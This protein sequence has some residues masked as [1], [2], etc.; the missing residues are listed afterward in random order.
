[1]TRWVAYRTLPG[2]EPPE[3]KYAQGNGGLIA[4]QVTGD[5]PADLV[6]MTGL[7]S[8]VD[9]RWDVPP[10]ARFLE[11]LSS[12]SRVISFDR[13]G[14]GAS[15][16]IPSGVLTWE[17]CADDLKVVLD[18]IACERAAIFAEVD[19]GPT[20]LLFAAMFPD[21]VSALVLA[22]GAARLVADDGYPGVPLEAASALVNMTQQGW[23]TE[24]WAE[25]V[26]ASVAQDRRTIRSLA[27]LQRAS[28][29]PTVAARRFR[30]ALGLDIRGVLSSIHVPTLIIQREQ[31][32]FVPTSIGRHLAENIPGA[33]YFE[34][35]G[36]DILCCTQGDREILER[37]QKF[38]TGTSEAQDTDRVL[39]TVLF[40]DI[41]D[42]TRRAAEAGDR[43]WKQLLDAHDDLIRQEVE[44][45]GGRIVKTT[46]DGALAT[47][48][49]PGRAIRC[50]LELHDKLAAIGV[51]IRAGLHSGEIELRGEDVGGIAVH[52]AA[53]VAA[54]ANAGEVLVSRT[55]NDLVA[56]SGLE[57]I[58]RG[59][60]ELKGVPGDW[61][62]FAVVR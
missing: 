57:F 32:M 39:A 42:S 6:H 8:H 44:R 5:G 58:D 26:A 38:L 1:L 29:T 54:A 12:F 7:A 56:G 51:P 46:G 16:P 43:H 45:F 13:R 4:Y 21:R 22:N 62:L 53:R 47:F 24:A 2:V 35:P 11:R 33:A 30:Y 50:A 19:D 37:V 28:A 14:F 20:A 52:L 36:G 49:S 41:V 27:K 61:R 9:V 10:M 34:T 59:M 25:L 31:S 23:G 48:D 17:E 40:T 15:D 60:H 55:L 18:A 3:T